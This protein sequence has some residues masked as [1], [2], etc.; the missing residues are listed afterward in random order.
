MAEHYGTVM[1]HD[2][3]VERRGPVGSAKG[4]SDYFRESSRGAASSRW[5][6][7]QPAIPSAVIPTTPPVSQVPTFPPRDST[8][9]GTGGRDRNGRSGEGTHRVRYANASDAQSGQAWAS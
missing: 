8:G 1:G 5:R 3:V 7:S 4:V 6:H 2:D 9:G